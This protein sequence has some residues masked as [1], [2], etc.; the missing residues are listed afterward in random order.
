MVE[1]AQQ[2]LQGVRV[3][4]IQLDVRRK[5]RRHDINLR[6]LNR[7]MQDHD[8]RTSDSNQKLIFSFFLLFSKS[9][10]LKHDKQGQK[11]AV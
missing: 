4:Q 2:F 3:F 6:W 11:F 8:A 9:K 1:Q 5:N 10:L 7:V